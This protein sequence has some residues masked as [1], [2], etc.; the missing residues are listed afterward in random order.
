MKI[1]GP[2]KSSETGKSKK[3][4]GVSKGADGTFQS[5]VSGGTS[6][7]SGATQTS[8]SSSISSVD[9]LLMAQGTEDPAQKKSQKRM[10]ERADGLLDK[11]NDLKVAILTG[12]VTVGHMVSIAD[13]A[14]THREKI[15][16]PDLSVLLD[17]ID[18]RAQIELAKIEVA[19]SRIK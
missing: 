14:A 9:A 8:V 10:R 15:T 13:I 1:T 2:N 7:A 3:S 6:E 5:L 16:D 12:N 19:Q 17:E 18:L 11:M 4:D